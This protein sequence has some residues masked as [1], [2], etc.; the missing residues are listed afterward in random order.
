MT[1]LYRVMAWFSQARCSEGAGL[2]VLGASAVTER[3]KRGGQRRKSAVATR[4]RRHTGGTLRAR[5]QQLST[6]IENKA[7]PGKADYNCFPAL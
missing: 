2:A 5:K 7:L 6:I 3:C 4:R 1:Q